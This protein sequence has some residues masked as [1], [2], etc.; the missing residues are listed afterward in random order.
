MGSVFRKI[1]LQILKKMI[2]SKLDLFERGNEK[3]Q[4][5]I[6][7][8]NEAPHTKKKHCVS[9]LFWFWFA[10]SFPSHFC[11]CLFFVGWLVSSYDSSL[12]GIQSLGEMKCLDHP[13]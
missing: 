12:L 3:D 13:R 2:I 8:A 4:S 7:M 9:L 11:F 1:P 5:S 10:C 6:I